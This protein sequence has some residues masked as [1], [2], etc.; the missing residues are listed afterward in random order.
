[1][2]NQLAH[3]LN[4]LNKLNLINMKKIMV[5]VFL[6]VIMP[7]TFAQQDSVKK[8]HTYK[9]GY[10]IVDGDTLPIYL[11]DDFHFRAL[12]SEEEQKAYKKLVRDIKKALPYAKLAAFR[13]QMMEDNLSLL[14]TEKARKKYIKDCEVA[15]KKE[16][17]DDLK[18]LTI[19]QGKLL[20]K[21]IHRETGKTTWDILKNY[22]GGLESIFWQSMAKTYGADTKDTF[23]PVLDYQIESII[24]RLELE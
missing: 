21:L 17:M 15:I 23:D 18:N 6:F 11:F 16:F 5:V 2:K 12:Q 3:N 8:K 19:T 9:I 4:Y 24:K 22:R 7:K 20:L 13:L 10:E 14:K 1:M